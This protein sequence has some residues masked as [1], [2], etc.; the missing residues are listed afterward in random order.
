MNGAE[1]RRER[2]RR[3]WSQPHLAELVGVGPRTIGN[4]ERGETIPKNKAARI[5]YVFESHPLVEQRSPL[6]DLP[7]IELIRELE[8][9][10]AQRGRRADDAVN[11]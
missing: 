7:D 2:E 5:D 3:G 8:R 4:W 10:A 6:A 11:G 1:I 9:R